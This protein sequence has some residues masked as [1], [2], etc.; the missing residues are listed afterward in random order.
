MRWRAKWSHVTIAL[1][2]I[3][4]LAIAAPA[5][6][7]PSL[8]KLV[9]KEVAKQLAG[10]TGPPGPQGAQGAAGAPGTRF[11]AVVAADGTL[12]RSNGG[13]TPIPLGNGTYQVFFNN[14]VDACSYAATLENTAGLISA[15]QGAGPNQVIVVTRNT[16]GTSTNQGFN[17]QVLC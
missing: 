15:M 17:L 13:V 9:Q 14:T 4:T 16:G 8:K 10:K 12:R 3:A 6:G 2:L 1:A 5:L 7:G 11:W